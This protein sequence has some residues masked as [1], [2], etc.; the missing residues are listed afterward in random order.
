MVLHWTPVTL[1]DPP[2]CLKKQKIQINAAELEIS[3]FHATQS[4][5]FSKPGAYITH[6]ATF[7]KQCIIIHRIIMYFHIKSQSHDP[8]LPHHWRSVHVL[9][10]SDIKIKFYSQVESSMKW[11]Y[12]KPENR[13]EALSNWTTVLRANCSVVLSEQLHKLFM[14]TDVNNRASHGNC[15]AIINPQCHLTLYLRPETF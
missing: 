6:N 14:L 15:T 10:W 13:T 11:K 8:T 4:S 7:A 12:S 5:S 3:P 1:L 2:D 9:F